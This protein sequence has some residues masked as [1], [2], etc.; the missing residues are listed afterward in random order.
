MLGGFEGRL[1]NMKCATLAKTSP[2]TALRDITDLLGRG[3]LLKEP[4]GGRSTSYA[5]R[6]P[7]TP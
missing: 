4:G 7:E 1:T 2:E 5:L 3:I 6:L